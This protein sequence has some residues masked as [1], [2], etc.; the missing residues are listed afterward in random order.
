MVTGQSSRANI[1]CDVDGE[2]AHAS[3]SVAGASRRTASTWSANMTFSDLPGPG[4]TVGQFYSAA[5]RALDRRMKGAQEKMEMR[6]RH[7]AKDDLAWVDSLNTLGGMD[8]SLNPSERE[9]RYSKLFEYATSA[10]SIIKSY[11]TLI[12][13]QITSSRCSN[14]RLQSNRVDRSLGSLS[15]SIC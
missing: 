1:R 9:E 2:Y 11:F 12:H 13:I 4:R 6:L 5:G 7:A 15:S 3:S 14:P 8:F 10:P